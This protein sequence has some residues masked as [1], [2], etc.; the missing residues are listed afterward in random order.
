MDDFPS[1]YNRR[2]ATFLAVFFG[3]FTVFGVLVVLSILTIGFFI[4]VLIIAGVIAAFAGLHYLIWGWWMSDLVAG[5][6]EEMEAQEEAED[7]ML[8]ETRRPR[9][10]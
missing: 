2:R 5:E 6:R 1:S 8:D 10:Y 7:E 4:Y 3:S 9:H